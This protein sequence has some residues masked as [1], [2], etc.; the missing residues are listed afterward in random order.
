[1]GLLLHHQRLE[2]STFSD[3]N[4][5]KLEIYKQENK[6]KIVDKDYIYVDVLDILKYVLDSEQDK[7]IVSIQNNNL[8]DFFVMNKPKS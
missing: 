4:L 7:V 1:M 5:S 3:K 6:L 8:L 2:K